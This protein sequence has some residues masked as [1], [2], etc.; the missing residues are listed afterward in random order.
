MTPPFFLLAPLSFGHVTP[1][2][3]SHDLSRSLYPVSCVLYPGGA[4]PRMPYQ[5]QVADSLTNNSQ[6]FA[7]VSVENVEA[8]ETSSRRLSSSE[9]PSIN[10]EFNVKL[11]TP[12]AQAPVLFSEMQSALT[13]VVQDHTLQSMLSRRCRFLHSC[14]ALVNG[15]V[16]GTSFK[17]PDS[18]TVAKQT[19]SPTALPSPAPTTPR[20]FEGELCGYQGF[21]DSEPECAKGLS[22]VQDS[23]PSSNYRYSA[24][25][26]LPP[27]QPPA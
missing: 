11:A 14:G 16:N 18:Y 17:S 22:C 6:T 26:P 8:S 12:R 24:A 7:N 15:T 19:P 4:A 1:L 9:A 20:A 25:T 13:M 27:S 10:I 3:T 21:N 2:T 23:A 5:P